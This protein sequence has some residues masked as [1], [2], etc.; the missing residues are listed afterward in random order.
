MLDIPLLKF[1]STDKDTFNRFRKYVKPH[2][3]TRETTQVLTDMEEYWTAF[4]SSDAIEWAQ[5][6]VWF[7][8]V[9]HPAFDTERHAMYDAL[10]DRI[11]KELPP[12]KQIIDKFIELDYTAQVRDV[13]DRVIRSESKARL[14]DIGP[15]LE[16]Y[17]DEV[18]SAGKSDE[19]YFVTNN[20]SAILDDLVR[21]SGLEW[22]LE[23]LNVGIGPL[24]GG[25]FV[26]IGARPETGKTT[27]ACSEMTYMT[28]Q[29]PLDIDSIFFNNEEDGRKILIRMVQA[30]L[31][32]TIL[33]IAADEVKASAAYTKL[34]GRMDRIKVVHKDSNLS[35][36]DIDRYLKT[37]K[38]GLA[39]INVLDKLRG[40]DK[41]ENDVSRMRKLAQYVRNMAVR[42]KIPIIAIM[43]ADASGEGKAWL[44]QSQ[45]YGSKTGIQGEADVIAMI[46]NTYEIDTRFIHIAKNKLPGGP[47]TKAAERHGKF[48][49]RFDQ[50]RARYASKFY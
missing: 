10:F 47:R 25:D 8:L 13:C 24:H 35:V 42:Y 43:Q 34:M 29:L 33:D 1:L 50:E 30:A 2:T 32:M 16:R 4:P 22:R 18:G 27:F 7:K 17:V 21:S 39:C 49:V 40:F 23:D 5:F 11:A 20:I 12:D 38:Y 9:R 37:G 41:D 45:L 26:I 31:N 48:E 46:G 3:I 6:K 14:D 36:H 15:M 19:D 28:P 44:D